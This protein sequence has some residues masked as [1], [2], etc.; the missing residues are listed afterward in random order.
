M[1]DSFRHFISTV[2]P[3][4]LHAQRVPFTH[5]K[6]LKKRYYLQLFC[7]KWSYSS[8]FLTGVICWE[9]KKPCHFKKVNFNQRQTAMVWDCN[10]IT[11][12]TNNFPCRVYINFGLDHYYIYIQIFSL[13]VKKRSLPYNLH[14]CF[15]H[16]LRVFY[17]FT[18]Y[19]NEKNALLTYLYAADMKGLFRS[20]TFDEYWITDLVLYAIWV[21]A[22]SNYVTSFSFPYF[23]QER[24]FA[25]YMSN[26]FL[27]YNIIFWRIVGKKLGTIGIAKFPERKKKVFRVVSFEPFRK[28]SERYRKSE[29]FGNAWRFEN[30]GSYKISVI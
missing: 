27:F 21:A 9:Q 17:S 3:L 13:K 2:E 23:A 28:V 16:F 8:I 20:L 12:F 6:I 29:R 30:L 24:F 15:I 7:P 1:V 19:K 5:F 18:V 14:I 22:I 10:L 4:N 26:Y 11:F 25:Y